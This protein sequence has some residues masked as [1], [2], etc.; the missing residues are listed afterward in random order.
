MVLMVRETTE[1]ERELTPEEIA[2]AII[3]DY[4]SVFTSDEDDVIIKLMETNLY[5]NHG[6][7]NYV[8]PHTHG[9]SGI[10][11]MGRFKKT[12]ERPATDVEH[13]AYYYVQ[14][15]KTMICRMDCYECPF[16]GN[17]ISYPVKYGECM[18][19]VEGKEFYEVADNE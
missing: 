7:I 19:I 14:M 15:F 5:Y 13:L 6:F 4:Q 9:P 2:M 3:I 17:C 12:I 11:Y 16:Q 1:F 10:L 18:K 8:I